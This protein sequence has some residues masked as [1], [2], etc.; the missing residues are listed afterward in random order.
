MSMYQGQLNW[1]LFLFESLNEC[2]IAVCCGWSVCE[3]D[4]WKAKQWSRICGANKRLLELFSEME[5]SKWAVDRIFGGM[6]ES[7]DGKRELFLRNLQQCIIQEYFKY[8]TNH[9]FHFILLAESDLVTFVQIKNHHRTDYAIQKNLFTV[10]TRSQTIKEMYETAAKT[11]VPAIAEMD[12]ILGY[13]DRRS[14]DAFICTPIL[15]QLRRRIR[16]NVELDIETRMVINRCLNFRFISCWLGC[17]Q[18]EWSLFFGS[19]VSWT[20]ILD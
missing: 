20:L 13:R 14:S 12:R 18:L 4:E 5:N 1:N 9:S 8:K 6:F 16:A 11:P 7:F 3:V 19:L 10:E 15:G 17:G 2:F